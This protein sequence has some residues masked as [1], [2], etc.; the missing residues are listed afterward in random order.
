MSNVSCSCQAKVVAINVDVDKAI[1]TITIDLSLEDNS[2][3]ASYYRLNLVVL[4]SSDTFVY[5]F[6]FLPCQIDV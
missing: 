2:I 6:P 3:L 4:L 5:H 1:Y